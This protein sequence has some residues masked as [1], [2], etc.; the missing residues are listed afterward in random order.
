VAWSRVQS[1]GGF[2]YGTT[3][4]VAFTTANV[5][6]GN[7]IIA[8]V[9]SSWTDA[10]SSVADGSSNAWTLLGSQ[11]RSGGGACW[12]YGRDVPSGDAGTKPTLTAT[13]PSGNGQSM[14]IQEIS[15][16]ATGNTTA[17]LD[18]SPAGLSGTATS[19]GSPSYS[20]TASGEY[21]V[22][23]YGD[24][25]GGVTLTPAS[26]WTG[27]A[28][29]QYGDD[30]DASIE[31]KSSTGGAETSG[32]TGATANGWSVLTV[33]FKLAGGAAFTPPPP[34]IVPQA[35]QRASYW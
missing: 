9:A 25:D 31:Y 16:L 32:W 5:T 14:V 22:C 20:S 23:I 19:T 12:L 35:V 27:D 21:L 30:S 8:A 29:N 6:S 11:V 34:L 24:A 3:V 33:A 2:N 17:M 1:A 15:G 26:G 10:P 7:K 28:A 4:A 18:G 13:F